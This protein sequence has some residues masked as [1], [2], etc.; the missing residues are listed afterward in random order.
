[1][2]KTPHLAPLA[3]KLGIWHAS[4]QKRV[5]LADQHTVLLSP[6]VVFLAPLPVRLRCGNRLSA[7]AGRGRICLP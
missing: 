2:P 1:M 5:D 3:S 6:R 4:F 7:N